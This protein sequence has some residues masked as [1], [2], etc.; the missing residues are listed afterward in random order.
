MGHLGE[1]WDVRLEESIPGMGEGGSFSLVGGNREV[2]AISCE[3]AVTQSEK[4][5]E[6]GHMQSRPW[7]APLRGPQ[8]HH[9]DWRGQGTRFCAARPQRCPNVC[10]AGRKWTPKQARAGK[11]GCGE[12]LDGKAEE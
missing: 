2:I 5:Q 6:R 7:T 3:E 9:G 1:G 11:A 10:K 8:G 12:G 4:T